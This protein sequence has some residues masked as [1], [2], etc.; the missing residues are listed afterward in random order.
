[1]LNKGIIVSVQ[2]YSRETIEELAGE[3]TNAGAVALRTDK[4]IRL[5]PENKIPIIGLWKTKVKDPCKEAYI[6]PT[7]TE[8]EKVAQWADYVA[9]D[10][11]ELNPALLHVSNYCRT[12]KI[13]V[14]A[15]IATIQDYQNIKENDYYYT[16]IATTLSVFSSMYDPDFK[17]LFEL[18]A[19]GEKNIIAEGNFKI[20]QDVAKAYKIGIKNI[21]IG[22]AIS[23]IYKLTQKFTSIQ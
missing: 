14:V 3:A 1:M 9:I 7:K 2:M 10:Y 18:I 12:M 11:R 5:R 13:K 22:G 6:T 8:I 20:R 23:N 4:F 19:A 16:Y 15:D 17:L 21:C